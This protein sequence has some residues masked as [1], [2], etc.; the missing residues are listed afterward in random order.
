MPGSLAGAASAGGGPRSAGSPASGEEIP[1]RRVTF[2][3]PRFMGETT[4][5]PRPRRSTMEGSPFCDRC[6]TRIAST[7]ELKGLCARCLL[8][9]GRDAPTLAFT[10]SEE[11]TLAEVR[12]WFPHLE[13][14]A[15]IGRGGMGVVY[16]ARQPRLARTV[17]LKVLAPE[18]S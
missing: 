6:G 9:A 15:R 3:A 11:P 10:E 12:E 7:G 16:R 8:E 4:P 2:G 14:E 13:V 17:A 1:G 5:N 18:L